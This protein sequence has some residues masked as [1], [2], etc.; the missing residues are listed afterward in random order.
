MDAVPAATPLH[1]KI[2]LYK[3]EEG[4]ATL[5]EIHR[6]LAKTSSLN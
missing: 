1:P 5:E 2:Q 4:T 6:Y 3:R